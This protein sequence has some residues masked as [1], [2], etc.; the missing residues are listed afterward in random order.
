MN[1]MTITAL[2]WGNQGEYMV[3]IHMNDDKTATNDEPLFDRKRPSLSPNYK[4]NAMKDMLLGACLCNNATQQSSTDA[5]N[6]TENPALEMTDDK[7]TTPTTKLVGDAA[8]VA[9]YR[10]CQE[11]CSVDIEHVKKVNPRINVVPF[12][13]KNKFMITANILER[14]AASQNDTVL[15]ILKGAPDFVLSRCTTYKEDEN[16]TEKPMTEE[17]KQSIQQRQ[18][19]LGKSGYRVIAMLQQTMSKNTYDANIEAY[20]KSKKQNQLTSDEPDLSGLPVNNYCFLGKCKFLRSHIVRYVSQQECSLYSIRLVLK[21]PM[22]FS[23]LVEL[24]FV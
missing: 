17:F 2:L 14:T 22:L 11:K 4:S 19:A 10:L 3:P 12:N 7:T 16:T 20:R 15:I 6:G 13:S 5:S 24:R 1:Q 21:Y 9:L 23:R 18:E 8:D